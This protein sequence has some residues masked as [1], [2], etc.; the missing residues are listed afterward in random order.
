MGRPEPDRAGLDLAP[1]VGED[2][3][4]DRRSGERSDPM[5][6]R[7]AIALFA[8][9]VVVATSSPAMAQRWGRE[10]EPREGA[11][12]YDDVNYGGNYFCVRAGES[13]SSVPS[14]M[15]D[16]ISSIRTFGG[17]EVRVF[18]DRQFEGSSGQFDYD[19]PNLKRGAWND[20]ISSVQVRDGNGDRG[21]WRGYG[22]LDRYGRYSDR[23]DRIVRRAYEDVLGREPD[24][25]GLRSYREHVLDDGWSETEVR[26]SLRR[27][28]EYR[29]RTFGSTD[30]YAMT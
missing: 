4:P 20:Q 26:E 22:S 8:C 13:L 21:A 17:A 12:F 25:E 18:R 11:C 14:R 1:L 10:P 24:P 5:L 27:S 3:V 9:S 19:V 28:A 29:E 2:E 6:E 16:R 30:R 23:A 7:C 15:N